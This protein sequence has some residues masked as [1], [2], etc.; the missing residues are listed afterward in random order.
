MRERYN[1]VVDSQIFGRLEFVNIGIDNGII[2]TVIINN[3]GFTY[4]ESK[5]FI[6]VIYEM[7]F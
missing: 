5:T 4:K 3:I 7:I 6:K 1:N 2:K